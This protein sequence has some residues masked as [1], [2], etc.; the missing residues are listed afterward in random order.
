MRPLPLESPPNRSKSGQR[1][2]SKSF[3]IVLVRGD[4]HVE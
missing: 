4:V 3:H 2:G 1:R